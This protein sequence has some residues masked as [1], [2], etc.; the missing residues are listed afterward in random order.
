MFF[1]KSVQT[2]VNM[3]HAAGYEAYPVGGCVRDFLL[4]RPCSDFDITTN[5]LPE[6]TRAV[7]AGFPVIETGI[8]HGTVTV[9]FDTPLE[10]TTFRVD[11]GYTDGR[12]P[13]AVAFTRSLTEDLA[14]RDFTVNAMAYGADIIDPFGGKADLAARTIRCVGNPETRF[15]EDALRILRGLRFAATLDFE[16]EE[17]T[18]AAMA[19]CRENLRFVSVERITEEIRKLAC[20]VSAARIVRAFRAVLEVV[21]PGISPDFE[22]LTA[23][24]PELPLRLAALLGNA[25]TLGALRL[26][27][28]ERDAVR[29]LL[30][31]EKP[32]DT[33]A[34][35]RAYGEEKSRLLFAYHGMEFT[36]PDGI[37]SVAQLAVGGADLREAGLCGA[38]IGNALSTLLD[39]VMR[40]EVPNER[41]ALLAKIEEM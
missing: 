23:L 3:L 32:S 7:F 13:D 33:K 2:A 6:E 26:S 11:L 24:P 8:K 34:A 29:C 30:A 21:L 36:L 27:N 28:K 20:G 38:E 40:G 41:H 37:W 9:V 10:I 14:R 4:S 19:N 25:E 35:L 39:V 12:H 17:K 1:P 18:A 22:K 16:I 31:A 5:A 15:G